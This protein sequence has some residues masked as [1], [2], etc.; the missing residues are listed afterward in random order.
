M[1]EKYRSIVNLG[2][3]GYMSG[4]F[5]KIE[6]ENKLGIVYL[7]GSI[8]M[9]CNADPEENRYVNLS[10]KWWNKKF[11]GSEI[12]FFNAGIGATTSQFGAARVQRD[13]LDKDPDLVFIEFSVNDDD[14]LT[15]M[16]TYESLV[17]R[18]LKHKSVK[19]VIIINNLFYDTGKNA[20]GIHNAVGIH[21]GLP[22]VSM[23]DYI[24]PQILSGDI[25]RSI[26]TDDMLH[27]KNI[28]HKTIAEI[29]V[30]LLETEYKYYKCS[31]GKI[32]KPELAEKLTPCRYEDAAVFQNFNC[33]PVL[34]G[35]TED[36]N[37]IDRFSDP[38]KNGWVAGKKGD[39]IIFNAQGNIIML[40]WRRTVDKPAPIACAV[41]DG[42]ESNRIILDANFEETWGDLCCLTTLCENAGKGSH[43]VEV[44][45]EQ[46]GR[47][48]N[49]FM[50]ISLITADN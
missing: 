5:Q 23:R 17:R 43:T 47:S 45:I 27:P 10:A 20:Q 11:P 25:D 15:F 14:D 24:Y 13:V 38:F 42:N 6:S 7:G 31:G 21:Y 3:I 28:G 9:G 36:T 49:P 22:I 4:V 50:L 46:E 39:S 34:K 16:E 12:T 37:K 29:I 33:K 48:D 44:R 40:Q 8:T 2:D 41:I 32:G 18:I 35:F 1:C 26:Y 19:A 30:D